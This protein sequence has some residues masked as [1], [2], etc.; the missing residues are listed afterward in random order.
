M[1][2]FS[3]QDI[4]ARKNDFQRKTQNVKKSEIFKKGRQYFNE[5]LEG[6]LDQVGYRN[7]RK[8][9]NLYDDPQEIVDDIHD[10]KPILLVVTSSPREHVHTREY[11]RYFHDKPYETLIDIVNHND[12]YKKYKVIMRWHPAG[13]IKNVLSGEEI[14]YDNEK[15]YDLAKNSNNIKHYLPCS[16]INTYAI[17]KKSSVVLSTG[18]TVGYIAAINGLPLVI[19]GQIAH[20]FQESI[21]PAFSVEE[22]RNLLLSDLQ[23]KPVNDILR[24]GYWFREFGEPMEHV[25][26]K[27]RNNNNKL[28][29]WVSLHEGD[30]FISK[31]VHPVVKNSNPNRDRSM[32]LLVACYKSYN[33]GNFTNALRLCQ[34]SLK[35][36]PSNSD[37][38]SFSTLLLNKIHVQGSKTDH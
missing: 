34:L 2:S 33:S 18:S 21:Y 9:C 27:R 36:D 22:A 32:E 23:P 8:E 5:Y 30:K 10:N 12:I 38:V 15:I 19:Y 17:L 29:W 25:F 6:T 1:N 26:C 4:H 24:L 31:K 35:V 20:L 13:R 37:A 16:N 14:A 3:P 11:F 7:F 28:E